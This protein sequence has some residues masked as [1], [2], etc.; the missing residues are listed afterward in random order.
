MGV[1][2]AVLSSPPAR[3]VEFEKGKLFGNWDTTITYGVQFRLDGRDDELIGLANG[4]K[5]FSVNGDD[6]DLN[7]GTGLS[8]N[9]FKLTTE[10][11][12]NYKNFGGFFRGFGFYDIE[13][14]DGDR[15]RTPLSDQALRR[16]GSRAEVLDAFVWFKFGGG[17]KPGELRVGQQVLSWGESTFIQG[18]INTINPIDV[19][20]VRFPGAELRQ[21]LLPVGLVWANFS[22]SLNT[23]IE[24]FYQYEWD[25][26]APAART[27]FW[28]SAA[29]A[30]WR[31][32]P[33]PRGPSWA[34]RAK[35][36]TRMPTTAASTAWPCDSSCRSSAERN[37]AST[38]SVTTVAC[39]P[40]T[41]SRARSP[42]RSRP[43]DSAW[44]AVPRWP[45][46]VRPT[47]VIR[48]SPPAARAERGR[49]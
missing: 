42:G 14:E 36:R 26:T 23:T 3:P 11:E 32:T 34:S 2:I 12:L 5:A 7:Y 17:G 22:L 19:S 21:A 29:R 20:A 15:A 25:P 6:G 1:A 45:R 47:I 30:I 49:A 8:S 40:S 13:N 46:S 48:R 24:G 18:G 16:V 10:I 31:P 41:G 33:A 4:G 44:R 43:A 27:S 37:S 35:H 28:A 9:V 39:R 38:T